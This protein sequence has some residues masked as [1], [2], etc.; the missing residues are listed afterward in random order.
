[1]IFELFLTMKVESMLLRIT[2]GPLN[3]LVQPLIQ[4]DCGALHGPLMTGMR[5][6]RYAIT[7]DILTCPGNKRDIG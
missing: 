5:C 2:D 6:E 4:C 1:M 3:G 7:G